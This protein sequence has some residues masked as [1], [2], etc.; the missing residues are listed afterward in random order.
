MFG[1]NAQ[2]HVRL[3]L[4]EHITTN[5]SYQLS[6]RWRGGDDLGLLQ[7]HDLTLGTLPWV[8]LELCCV[9]KYTRVECE[10]TCL[11]AKASLNLSHLTGQWSQAQLSSKSTTESKEWGVAMTQ[12]KSRPLILYESCIKTSSATSRQLKTETAT[13]RQ[14]NRQK[15]K[16]RHQ[17]K[18][19][20]AQSGCC[21][22]LQYR[23]ERL[24]RR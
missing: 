15:C 4:N 10:A 21:C 17:T 14:V 22:C 5:T 11:T 24:S 3:K 7:A 18:Q 2:Y 6:A 19:A 16:I 23:S 12:S 13:E 9:P 8:D 1:H 20:K